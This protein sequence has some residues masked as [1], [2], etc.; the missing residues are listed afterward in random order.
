MTEEESKTKWCPYAR[1]TDKGYGS[2]NRIRFPLLDEAG[3]VVKGEKGKWV[4]KP[5][6]PAKSCM[7]L[8]QKCMAWRFIDDIAEG[9]RGDYLKKSTTEGYCGLAEKN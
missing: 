6:E 4:M 5:A 9:S 2:F 3:I 8:G 1:E 7:C